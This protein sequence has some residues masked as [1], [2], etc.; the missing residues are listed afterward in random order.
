MKYLKIKNKGELDVRLLTLMGGT[1]KR[2]DNSKIGTFGSGTKYAMAY[3]LRNNIDFEIFSGTKQ[4]HIGVVEE[5]IQD[6]PFKILTIGGIQ[7]SITDSMGPDWEPWMVVREIYSNAID[8]GEA[9]YDIVNNKEKCE[10]GTTTFYIEL[11]PGIM[12]VYNNWDNYFIV[13]KEPFYENDNCKIFPQKGPLKIYKQGILVYSNDS[14]SMFNYDFKKADLNELREYK[15]Y[16]EGDLL[17]SICG[18]T[19]KNVVKYFIENVSEDVEEGKLGYDGYWAKNYTDAWKE[20]L[21]GCKII[22]TKAKENLQAKGIEVDEA[23]YITVPKAL[24]NGLSK[25]YAGIGAL[26]VSKAV[27]EFFEIYDEKLHD[28]VRKAE[29]LLEDSGYFMNPELTYKYGVFGDKTTLAKIDLDTKTIY[30]S[31]KH[32]DQDLFSIMTMLVEENE[33]FK[34]GFSDHT[35]AFQ[36][37][38]IDLY[39]NMLVEK[40]KVELM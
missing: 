25:K 40:E 36:Q 9:Q 17:E 24:Y 18:I 5:T 22:H 33:H 6:T 12:E 38:F 32:M 30:I 37:H 13:G 23:A 1:T 21:E 34:T 27:N 10:A 26:R 31:E 29:S 11:T 4:T 39:V 35:R 7:T 16:L 28:K 3:L 2:N 14:P 15:G 8:E 20:C 19:D